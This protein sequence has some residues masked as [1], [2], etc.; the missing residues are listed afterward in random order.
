VGCA[1]RLSPFWPSPVVH[2][3]PGLSWSHIILPVRA[4]C[5][6]R[7]LFWLRMPGVVLCTHARCMYYILP[8]RR[9]GSDVRF[10]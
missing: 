5:D 6:E 3:D 8:V 7:A 10:G 4:D 1:F 9:P 2:V